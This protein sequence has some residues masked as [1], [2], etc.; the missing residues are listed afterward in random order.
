MAGSSITG[1]K[2][3]MRLI[4]RMRGTAMRLTM[5]A[6]AAKAGQKLAKIAKAEVPSR[7]KHAR[8]GLGWRRLKANEA[9]GGGAK[10][11]AGVA[12]TAKKI[13]KE[14]SRDRT[15][16]KGVGI[17][18][19]NIHWLIEGAGME[20][21]RKTGKS[22]GPKRRTGTM[23]PLMRSMKALAAQNKST[24]STLWAFGAKKQLAKEIKKGKAF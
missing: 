3:L 2:K 21:E 24:L 14:S 5:S 13:A 23:Q 11:G 6:G 15:G 1:D 22:G 9:P 7:M 10:I 19:R 17:G 12:R 18:A 16:R 8:K 4:N 20:K